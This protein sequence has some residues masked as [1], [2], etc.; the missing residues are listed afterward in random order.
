MF[1]KDNVSVDK[2][3]STLLTACAFNNLITEVF[4]ILMLVIYC[5][6]IMIKKL[7]Y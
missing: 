5:F 2:S 3:V 6:V 7:Y 4:Q 1:L